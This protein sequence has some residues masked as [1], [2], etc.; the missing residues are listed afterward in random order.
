MPVA[1]P[2]GPLTFCA[3]AL[4]GPGT[5]WGAP[6]WPSWWPRREQLVL[7]HSA[8]EGRLSGLPWQQLGA[9]LL[10]WPLTGAASDWL[11]LQLLPRSAA[12]SL[13]SSSSLHP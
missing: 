1:L 9:S 5:G 10:G 2:T 12:R 6:G 13:I 11:Q 4:E 3:E 7:N 8:C